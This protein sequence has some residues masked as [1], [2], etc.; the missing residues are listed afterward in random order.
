MT[1]IWKAISI[2]SI[3][4]TT[5]SQTQAAPASVVG[6]LSAVCLPTTTSPAGPRRCKRKRTGVP[7]VHVLAPSDEC[8]I[9]RRRLDS[10]APGDDQ[11]V[12]RGTLGR[13]R[14]GQQLHP[15]RGGDGAARLKHDVDC[16]GR[17][18]AA[19]DVVRRG[20]NLQRPGDVKYLNLR[21]G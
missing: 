14:V 12:Q 6:S 18:I 5:R 3:L 11:R 4:S 1:Q 10:G 16:V 15:R 19:S 20:E 7:G 21:K 2:M 8:F 17:N 9:C 13:E